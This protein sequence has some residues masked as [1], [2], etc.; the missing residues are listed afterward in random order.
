MV[1]TEVGSFRILEE[2]S[3]GQMGTV[4]KALDVNL[5]R[6]VALRA[7]NLDFT[8]NPEVEQRFRAEIKPL[9]DLYHTNLVALHALLIEQGRPWMVTE[10]VEGETFEQMLRRRGPIPS[11][12]AIALFRQALFGIGYAHRKGLVHRDITPGNLIL[13]RDGVVKVMDFG[14]AKAL[15]ARGVAKAG[16]RFGKPAYMSPEQF[17]NRAVDARSDIYSLGIVLYEMLAGKVPFAA[18][19]DY[20]V[21]ADHVNTPPPA[22]SQFVAHIPKA[23]EQAVLKALEKNPEAR[24]QSVAE[25]G[26]ALSD[27]HIVPTAPAMVAVVPAQTRPAPIPAV[28]PSVPGF[29]ATREQKLIAAAVV[30]ILGLGGVLAAM[31]I[32]TNRAAAAAAQANTAAQAQNAA[33]TSANNPAPQ[34]DAA[35]NPAA[36]SAPAPDASNQGQPVAPPDGVAV[37]PGGA[38]TADAGGGDASQAPVIP[39]G[40]VVAVRMNDAVSSS[41]N[42]PGQTFDA[43]VDA[44]VAVAGSVLVPAG[45]DATLRLIKVAQVPAAERSDVQLQLVNLNINGADYPARSSVFEQQSLPKTK[46]SVA[47]AGARAAF[48][49]LGGFLSHNGAGN[50][51]AAGAASTFVVYIAPQTRIPF[52]LRKSITLSQ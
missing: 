22:L 45:S 39:A 43:S 41:A 52:T 31:R 44:D 18:D 25:F 33:N 37:A 17:L 14:L 5:D 23:A 48:G 51:A 12:E 16:T 30:A 13:N 4:H 42:L 19:N 35:A 27:S 2:L 32:Q 20:Q 7:L 15:S 6:I 26:A 21:M 38:V 24:F 10:F 40:T 29:F 49:A 36:N 46:K 3:Q 50:G 28:R 11:E 9:G 8:G 1:G 47:A 34:P